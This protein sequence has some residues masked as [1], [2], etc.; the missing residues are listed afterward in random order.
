MGFW[1]ARPNPSHHPK[2]F[3]T[4]GRSLCGHGSDEQCSGYSRSTPV[5]TPDLL[6]VCLSSCSVIS[7]FGSRRLMT[8]IRGGPASRLFLKSQTSAILFQ[9]HQRLRPHQARPQAT[10]STTT[11]SA[12][13]TNSPPSAN[14]PQGS[15]APTRASQT[16]SE[17]LASPT[18]VPPGTTSTTAPPPAGV[19]LTVDA[20]GYFGTCS[21]RRTCLHIVVGTH[22]HQP[23]P[24]N[25]SPVVVRMKPKEHRRLDC[26][27]LRA[28]ASKLPPR[29]TSR[30][31]G[32]RPTLAPDPWMNEMYFAPGS[33]RAACPSC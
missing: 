13:A 22:M 16:P 7:W 25:L 23:G 21:P 30:R 27:G 9:Q 10:T 29:G 17:P 24:E 26:V 12:P 28:P 32:L 4:G 5:W 6:R 1:T 18:T 14:V 8:L 3:R 31:Y 2:W 33:V 19:A 15:V 11:T 20:T